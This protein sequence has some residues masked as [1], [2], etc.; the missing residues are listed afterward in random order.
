MSAYSDKIEK[1]KQGGLYKNA[2][3]KVGKP[4][5]HEIAYLAQDVERFNKTMDILYFADAN[6]QLQVNTTNAETLIKLRGDNPDD[7]CGQSITLFLDEYKPG[8]FGIRVRA[9][10]GN[11]S[12]AV[13]R[14][15]E[16]PPYD[17]EIPY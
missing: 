17:D 8:A 1:Q 12:R 5:V 7:W 14:A 16:P 3:F 9:A 13:T 2:D 15:P 6:K 4:V 10:S 11:G